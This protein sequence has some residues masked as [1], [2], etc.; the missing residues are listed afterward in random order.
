MNIWSVLSGMM[1]SYLVIAVLIDL[2]TCI[3]VLAKLSK[4]F[5]GLT[6]LAV[7]NALPDALTTL[8]LAKHGQALTGITGT[9]AGQLF[10]LL[11]GFGL[12]QLQNTL[13]LGP[14]TFNLFQH[15]QKNIMNIMVI[16]IS[17][18][19]LIVTLLYGVING[20]IFDKKLGY[21]LITIYVVFVSLATFIQI[22]ALI[23]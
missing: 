15:P 11:I 14:Q 8:A 9:Y 1:W 2:L 6:V 18:I 17:L 13:R 7:G 12:A 19:N 20:K 23:P 3:G 21:I 10:G 4:V 16:V 5:I 22:S